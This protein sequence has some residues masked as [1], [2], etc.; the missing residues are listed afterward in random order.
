MT[1]AVTAAAKVT[2]AAF[3]ILCLLSIGGA[4]LF[5]APVLVP[6]HVF[7]A[8]RSGPVGAGA[9]ALLAGLSI[10]EITLFATYSLVGEVQPFIWLVPVAAL[11]GTGMAVMWLAA[12][13]RTLPS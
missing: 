6:L 10:G 11:A 5:A 12:R 9:W 13:V 2:L 3:T 7:V 8:T 1:R 4:M